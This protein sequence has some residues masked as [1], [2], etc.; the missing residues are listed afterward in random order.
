MNDLAIRD[1]RVTFV[2]SPLETKVALIIIAGE[3]CDLLK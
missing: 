3:I 2:N 1:W